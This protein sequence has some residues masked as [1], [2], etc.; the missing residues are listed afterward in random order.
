MK[1][2]LLALA[3]VTALFTGLVAPSFAGQ[4]SAA[5]RVTTSTVHSHPAAFDKTRFLAH[6]GLAYFAFH[7]W[8]YNPYKAGQLNRS[9][10]LNLLKAGLAAFFAYREMKSAY[11]IAKTSNSKTLQILIAPMSALASRFQALGGRL[12]SGQASP[13]DIN[14]LNT[15]ASGFQKLAGSRGFSFHDQPTSSL[16]GTP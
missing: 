15:Q 1:N 4:A 3:L 7:H 14:G 11:N 8:V 16:A 13:A 2:K 6:L 9:H 12:R 10:K 5:S